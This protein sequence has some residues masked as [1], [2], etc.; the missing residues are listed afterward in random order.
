MQDRK[1]FVNTTIFKWAIF[2]VLLAALTAWAIRSVLM[3]DQRMKAADTSAS[4][5]DSAAP[6]SSINAVVRLDQVAGEELRGTLLERQSDTVFRKPSESGPTVHAVLTPETSVVM[7][8]PQDIAAGAIVQLDGT[9]D[10]RHILRTN[11]IVIL[12]GYVRLL[13]GTR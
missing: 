12:T 1:P 10:E 5:F 6:G 4:M 3:R 13:Q 8:K 2:V 11:Q 9:M 7:G